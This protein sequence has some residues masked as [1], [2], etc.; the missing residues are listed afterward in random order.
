V[1]SFVPAAA[2]QAAAAAALAGRPPSVEYAEPNLELHALAV[3]ISTG[4]SSASPPGVPRSRIAS[5][6]RPP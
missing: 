4:D 6:T 2:A 1:L 3:P 5:R